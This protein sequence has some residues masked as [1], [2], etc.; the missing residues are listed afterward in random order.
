MRYNDSTMV[1]VKDHGAVGD[2]VTDDSAAIT[3]AYTAAKSS[4]YEHKDLYFPIGNFLFNKAGFNQQ[5][6][7]KFVGQ[8]KTESILTSTDTFM[9]VTSSGAIDIT[10][11]N[12]TFEGYT[13]TNTMP[14]GTT[15]PSLYDFEMKNVICIC[16]DVTSGTYFLNILGTSAPNQANA[17]IPS[18]NIESCSFSFG[19][20]FLG[21]QFA[22]VNSV[23][24]INNKVKCNNNIYGFIRVT[25]I[26]PNGFDNIHSEQTNGRIEI[27][28]NE[29]SAVNGATVGI[30]LNLNRE[31][32]ITNPVVSG[33]TIDGISEEGIA[34]DGF[35]N[36][37]TLANTICTGTITS[38]ANDGDGRL[39]IGFGNMQY[40]TG[41][42]PTPSPISL[43]DDWTVFKLTMDKETGNDGQLI[44][45]HSFDSGSNTM[46]LNTRILASSVLLA[47]EYS[48]QN[49]VFGAVIENNTI[50]NG[51]GSISVGISLYLGCYGAQVRGNR[52][53]NLNRGV[54]VAGAKILS[55]YNSNSWNNSI[56]DN[57]IDSP[58]GV[59]MELLGL[60]SSTAKQYGNSVYNNTCR[61]GDIYITNQYD[62]NA[63]NNKMTTGKVVFDNT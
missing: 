52:M 32:P 59:A 14:A 5:Y 21:F 47:G 55:L 3:A 40:V 1:N 41:G 38:A 27:K 63:H 36:N 28:D 45:I 46:T 9:Q 20:L 57:I 35:G 16:G 29:F 8:S 12:L 42:T 23:R 60:F 37:E 11:I 56:Y 51:Y 26:P 22:W 25:P 19:L 7:G 17:V 50:F 48:V 58:T 10:I 2:G 61:G 18:I 43:R 54:L 34:I 31:Y 33:N 13:F 49:G 24:F 53:S 4:P 6:A 44:D 62:F 15:T 30:A 39:V